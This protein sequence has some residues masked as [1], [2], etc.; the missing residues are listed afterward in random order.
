MYYRDARPLLKLVEEWAEENKG[1][2]GTPAGASWLAVTELAACP[3]G[4]FVQE[5]ASGACWGEVPL[6]YTR[7]RSSDLTPHTFRGYWVRSS[8]TWAV[9]GLFPAPETPREAGG[10]IMLGGPRHSARE[11]MPSDLPSSWDYWQTRRRDIAPW[12]TET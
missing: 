11:L 6:G 1:Y 10:R 2:Y 3:P 8:G 12:E 7:V 5:L 4:Q 9:I